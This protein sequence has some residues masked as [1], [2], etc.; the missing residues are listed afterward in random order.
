MCQAE[1]YSMWNHDGCRPSGEKEGLNGPCVTRQSD[2]A[3]EVDLTAGYKGQSG[4]SNAESKQ[5][6]T[7]LQ[8]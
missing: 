7:S 4:A 1:L 3:A 5:K 6:I 2:V 8:N